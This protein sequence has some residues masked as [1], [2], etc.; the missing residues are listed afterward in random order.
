MS[1]YD[2]FIALAHVFSS[3]F[4]DLCILTIHITGQPWGTF[5][6][7]SFPHVLPW[8]QYS[9]HCI[10][11]FHHLHIPLDNWTVWSRC[12]QVWHLGH[13][14]NYLL[15][16]PPYSPGSKLPPGVTSFM[17]WSVCIIIS[18]WWVIVCVAWA[19]C[20]S[21]VWVVHVICYVTFCVNLS[22]PLASFH[23]HD[24]MPAMMPIPDCSMLLCL[25]PSVPGATAISMIGSVQVMFSFTPWFPYHRQFF[26]GV[27]LYWPSH[28]TTSSM[29]VWWGPRLP[30]LVACLL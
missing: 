6:F 10:R 13:T 5:V 28:P 22:T 1:V 2:I 21:I 25:F 9:W 11:L 24:Q 16:Q 8:Y 30:S 23:R 14:P 7:L 4:I 19:T 18:T 17:C 12:L 20:H 27:M 29:S 3:P 26:A 15:C